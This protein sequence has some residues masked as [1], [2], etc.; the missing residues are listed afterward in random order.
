LRRS[1]GNFAKDWGVIPASKLIVRGWI[2][3]LTLAHPE[4]VEPPTS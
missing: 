3:I 2:P 4:G 1:S